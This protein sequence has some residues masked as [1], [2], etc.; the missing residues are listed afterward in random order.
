MKQTTIQMNGNVFPVRIINSYRDENN[1]TR[2]H[3][4]YQT[5]KGALTRI[6]EFY[7]AAI[8]ANA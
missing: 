6:F 2:Y 3:G 7:D 1:Q 4:V 5:Q 8:V